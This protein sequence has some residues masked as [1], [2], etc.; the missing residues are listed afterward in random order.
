MTTPCFV[1]LVVA[2]T[3]LATTVYAVDALRPEQAAEHVGER[4]RVCGVVASAKFATSS[5]KQPTFLN[6]GTPYPQH[7]FTALIWGKDRSAFPYAPE[8]LMG[9]EICV[10]GTI[11][12]YRGK[13][14]IIVTHPSQIARRAD[15]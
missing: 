3:M 4:A 6:L 1:P 15:Q 8:S 12:G 7:I 14:E 2:L 11:A 5:R 10:Q 13:P 9:E